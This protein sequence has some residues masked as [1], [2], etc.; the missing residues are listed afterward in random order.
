MIKMVEIDIASLLV[1]Q[2]MLPHHTVLTVLAYGVPAPV[3]EETDLRGVS[4]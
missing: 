1:S 4:M 2:D 3:A